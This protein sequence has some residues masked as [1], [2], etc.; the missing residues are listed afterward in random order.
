MQ[1]L[2]MARV[3]QSFARP[4]IDD[5]E[6]EIQSAMQRLVSS[7]R[8]G[9][10]VAVT[11]GSR[12][13]NGI[14]S[15]LRAVAASLR[16]LGAEP[17][18]FAAMGSHGGGTASGQM[19]IL[20]HLGITEDSV[21]A[22]F[23]ITSEAVS[24][25]R[26]AGGHILYADAEAAKADG[27]FVVNRIKPHTAFRDR[28][29]SGIFKMLTVGMGKVPGATQ[30]HRLGPTA[31]YSSIVELGRMSLEKLP[32]IGGL[33]VVENG[34]EET[35]VTEVLLP[36]EMEAG[37]MRLLEYATGLLP[38]LPVKDL[39]ILIIDEIGKNFSGTGMDTNVVGRWKDIGTPFPADPVISR[40]V[41][42]RLSSASEGNANGIGLADF[43]T[44]KVVE[45]V[46]WKATLTNVRTTGFWG[47]AFM[48]PFPGSDRDAVEWALDSLRKTR[49]MPLAAARIRNTLHLDEVWLNERAFA[50]A[51]GCT[52]VGPFTPLSFS[53]EGDLKPLP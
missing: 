11:A 26:T 14:A 40:I 33:A 48:P 21:G 13:I 28:I 45:A 50:S 15:I 39:D 3:R 44:R 2:A 38:G 47:R 23:R 32:V 22:P 49:E 37:E 6:G 16:A 4:K 18:I 41:V 8:P 7:I 53:E 29:A 9:M 35:A 27:I 30:V 25:G 20:S 46:D 5:V 42:L 19:K 52:Q 24:L 34:F 36:A 43:T 31:I 51:R 10:S 12:G 1:R 17:F